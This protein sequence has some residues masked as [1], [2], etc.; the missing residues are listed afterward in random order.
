MEDLPE[1]RGLHL[2]TMMTVDRQ[3]PEY[4]CIPDVNCL[5]TADVWEEIRFSLEVAY[6][7]RLEL[8]VKLE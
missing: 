8:P 4:Q 7:W 2:S 1:M 3:K 6:D 5:A